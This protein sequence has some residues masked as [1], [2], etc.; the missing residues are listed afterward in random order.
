MKIA[1]QDSEMKISKIRSSSSEMV[2]SE[3][4]AE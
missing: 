4:A 3:N 1:G 2:P